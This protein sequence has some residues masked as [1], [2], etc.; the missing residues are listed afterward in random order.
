[1]NERQAFEQAL[2]QKQAGSDARRL[3]VFPDD[4]TIT[5]RMHVLYSDYMNDV[6]HALREMEPVASKSVKIVWAPSRAGYSWL[7]V[8]MKAA[9]GSSKTFK[10]LPSEPRVNAG[11]ILY[12]NGGY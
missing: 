12:K 8:T 3:G 9:D 2:A 4:W 5:R 11:D 10:L 1:M 7:M 6:Q